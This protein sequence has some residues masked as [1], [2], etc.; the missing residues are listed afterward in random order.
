MELI[1]PLINLQLQLFKVLLI[2][3]I[4]HLQIKEFNSPPN[5]ENTITIELMRGKLS[6]SKE[7]YFIINLL[8]G[9]SIT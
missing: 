3:F 8:I 6:F 9:T 4:Y 7:K 5:S 2:I 1:Q